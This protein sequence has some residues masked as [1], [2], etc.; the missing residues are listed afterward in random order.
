MKKI[1]EIKG[2]GESKTNRRAVTDGINLLWRHA[3]ML[4][5]TCAPLMTLVSVLWAVVSLHQLH[6]LSRQWVAGIP[7]GDLPYAVHSPHELLLFFAGIVVLAQFYGLFQGYVNNGFIPQ[8]N[9]RSIWKLT[10]N[11]LIHH[12]L[13]AYLWVMFVIVVYYLLAVMLVI[14]VPYLA[15]LLLP[16]GIFLLIWQ[17][18]LLTDSHVFP[19]SLMA[20]I[21]RSFKVTVRGFLSFLL[22]VCVLTI[23]QCAV[24]FLC[25][26]PVGVCLLIDG[27]AQLS[28]A[29]GDA[30][31]IPGYFNVFFFLA[32]VVSGY[33]LLIVNALNLSCMSM[34]YGAVV[35][36]MQA[37]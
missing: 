24:S 31:Q 9:M 26:V 1:K 11:T 17:M 7:Q 4:F 20:A 21:T 14:A 5:K 2:Y 19:G 22:V 16:L 23:V 29:M 10:W 6:T 25:L 12:T 15:I 32:A 8:V 30:A 36:R 35:A 13:V 37:K 3:W 34:T 18:N 28:L 27:Q 33:L